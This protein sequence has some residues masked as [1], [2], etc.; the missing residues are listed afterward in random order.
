[1]E[2]KESK[3][4]ISISNL[5]LGGASHADDVRAVA[6]A[7]EDHGKITPHFSARNGF[8]LNKSKTEV[9]VFSR[10]T[11]KVPLPSMP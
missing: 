7:T 11:S 4:G 3:A 6:T 9:V 5:Y 8:S 1:M 10:N 2:L